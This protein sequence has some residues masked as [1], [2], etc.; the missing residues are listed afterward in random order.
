VGSLTADTQIKL[1]ELF[2]LADLRRQI[3]EKM[4]Q[5]EKK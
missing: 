2:P 5:E 3:I 4:K 1:K